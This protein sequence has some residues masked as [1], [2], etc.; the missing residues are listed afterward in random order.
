LRRQIWDSGRIHV[1]EGP[2]ER[3]RENG[4]W[5]WSVILLGSPGKDQRM[6]LSDVHVSK[7]FIILFLPAKQGE[8]SERWVVGTVDGMLPSRPED[9]GLTPNT[10]PPKKVVVVLMLTLSFV[11]FLTLC[12]FSFLSFWMLFSFL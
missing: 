5:V 4:G 11:S 9:L 2:R 8:Y 1:P 6:L 3:D 12:W 10:P 7:Y